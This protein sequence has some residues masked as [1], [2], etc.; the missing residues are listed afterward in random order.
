MNLYKSPRW[1]QYVLMGVLCCFALVPLGF[2]LVRALENTVLFRQ[3][4][5]LAWAEQYL[6]LAQFE[7]TMFHDLA[8]W[9]GYGNTLLLTIPTILLIMLTSTLAA[10][11][12]ISARRR[13]NRGLLLFYVLLS[14]LPAQVLLVPNFIALS[15]LEMIGS[16]WSV[17]LASSFSPYYTYFMYRF[18]SQIPEEQLESARLEGAGDWKIYRRIVM[19]QLKSAVL[20]LLLIGAADFWSMVE[21]P[22]AL[23]QDPVMY[24]LSVMFRD[25]EAGM[26]HAGSILFSMPVLLVFLCC[27]KEMAEGLSR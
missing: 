17:I 5:L 23:L 27:G 11:G 1:I 13:K 22:L 4:D 10:Y 3:G 9:C 25:L 6:S 24:P 16:R 21:Q 18:A 14:L 20:A 15:W 8:F 12:M 26:V 7:Q 2:V 19:P